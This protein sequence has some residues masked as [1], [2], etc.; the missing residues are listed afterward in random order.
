MRRGTEVAESV[1]R[2]PPPGFKIGAPPFGPVS[3]TVIRYF[4]ESQIIDHQHVD[5]QIT[6]HE[7]VDSQILLLLLLWT[8]TLRSRVERLGHMRRAPHHGS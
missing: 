5:S 3:P 2:L 6:D 7:N 4:V 8:P 1:C